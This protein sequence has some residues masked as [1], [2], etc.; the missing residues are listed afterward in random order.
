MII[1]AKAMKKEWFIDLASHLWDKSYFTYVCNECGTDLILDA[2]HQVKNPFSRGR[3][4][5]CGSCQK[6]F[7]DSLVRLV[8]K[9]RAVTSTIGTDKNNDLVFQP[10][11]ENKEGSDLI[12]DEYS[13]YDQCFVLNI[14]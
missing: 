7:D 8:K 14:S 4:Y 1:N 11:P 2:E 9:P 13:K 12:E 6:T 5:F 3:G 10:I